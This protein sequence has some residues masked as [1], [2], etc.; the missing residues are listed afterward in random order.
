MGAGR[1]SDADY[2]SYTT[3]S[4]GS[5]AAYASRSVHE[6]FTSRSVPAALDPKRITLRE[7]CDSADNPNSTPII[8]G[9]DL[10]GSM[11]QYANMIAVEALPQLMGDIL[12]S[13]PV[14]DPHMMFMGVVD[15]HASVIHAPLQVSQFEA[16][17]RIIEQLNT[18]WI[19]GGGGGNDSEGYELP[20][21][22][23]ANKTTIDSYNKR[24]VK[25]F[26]F[27]MGDECAPYELTT[28][29]ELRALFG[30]GQYPQSITPQQLLDAAREKYHVF[31]IVIE[32][33]SYARAHGSHVRRTWTDLMGTSVLFLS[34]FRDLSELVTST[35]RIVNGEDINEVIRT[36]KNPDSL[37]HAFANALSAD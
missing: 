18:M 16:D 2:S 34:D 27:T 12:E 8:L 15:H 28:E 3:K 19:A 31:H 6:N 35:M 26:L 20:W 9:L 1:W 25:G 14:T 33:G 11:G 10:S 22:F 5:R 37:K 13:K 24:G 36:A 23:A 32:Q 29:Y 17:V 4:A 30:E 21:Y 7:S